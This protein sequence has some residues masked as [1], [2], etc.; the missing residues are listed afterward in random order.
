MRRA[1]EDLADEISEKPWT[2]RAAMGMNEILTIIE[3]HDEDLCCRHLIWLRDA[4][5]RPPTLDRAN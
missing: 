3:E 5:F 2:L 1:L 4:I